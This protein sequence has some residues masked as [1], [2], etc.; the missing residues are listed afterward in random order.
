MLKASQVP[1]AKRLIEICRDL[2]CALRQ[3]SPFVCQRSESSHTPLYILPDTP[4]GILLRA[5]FQTRLDGHIKELAAMGIE[6]DGAEQGSATRGAVIARRE[7]SE[8]AA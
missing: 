3:T 4:A 8:V 1:Y 7:T 5:E 2:Q 6:L